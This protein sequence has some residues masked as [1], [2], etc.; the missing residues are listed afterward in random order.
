MVMTSMTTEKQFSV[1][2][3]VYDMQHKTTSIVTRVEKSDDGK[4]TEVETEYGDDKKTQ[5]YKNDEI[6]KFLR[7]D[8]PVQF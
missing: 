4:V 7:E 5:V 6:A 8:I 1:G 2:I 3:Q